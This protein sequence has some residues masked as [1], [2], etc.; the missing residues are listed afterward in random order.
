[1]ETERHAV[2]R[3]NKQHT[4]SHCRKQRHQSS[5]SLPSNSPFSTFSLLVLLVLLALLQVSSCTLPSRCYQSPPDPSSCSGP[6]R[7]GFYYNAT[8]RGVTV[9]PTG[10]AQAISCSTL[11]SSAITL[12]TPPLHLHLNQLSA[13]G[14]YAVWV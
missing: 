5:P 1:M 14:R 3:Q 2:V 7:P 4:A 9:G 11:C 6:F 10:A 12:A 13:Q 8:S